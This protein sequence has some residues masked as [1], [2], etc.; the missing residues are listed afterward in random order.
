METRKMT[1]DSSSS[2]FILCL[3]SAGLSMR[4]RRAWGGYTKP[5]GD[6][7]GRPGSGLT[8]RSW[9]SVSWTDGSLSLDRGRPL[10][11]APSPERVQ[12]SSSR[13]AS[14]YH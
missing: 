2:V 13:S 10:A 12:T 14:V 3:M 4:T 8:L 7:G 11:A 6:R 5:G 1:S 9:P